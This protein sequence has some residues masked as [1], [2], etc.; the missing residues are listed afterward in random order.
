MK[1]RPEPFRLIEELSF[2][3]RQFSWRVLRSLRFLQRTAS[4]K[5]IT[6]ERDGETLFR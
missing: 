6:M 2:S 5:S 4:S 3:S 1:P